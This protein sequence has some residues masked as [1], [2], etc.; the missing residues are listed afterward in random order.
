MKEEP[1]ADCAAMSYFSEANFIFGQMVNDMEDARW[2]LHRGELDLLN[3]RV[4]AIR[5][6]CRALVRAIEMVEHCLTRAAKGEQ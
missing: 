6:N 3:L 2:K 4:E 1:T 5:K